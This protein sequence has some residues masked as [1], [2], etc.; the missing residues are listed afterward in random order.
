MKQQKLYSAEKGAELLQAKRLILHRFEITEDEWFEMMIEIGCLFGESF[1]R[2]FPNNITIKEALLQ[3]KP[4]EDAANWYWQ[5]WQFK[6]M[7]DDL[8]YV[9][10]NMYYESITYKELKEAMIS[11]E[12]L[13][14]DLLHHMN[15]KIIF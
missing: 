15:G 5:W 8:A 7:Q 6:W 4:D 14:T 13:E 12:M 11:E 3:K 2:L 1:S 9:R 10:S